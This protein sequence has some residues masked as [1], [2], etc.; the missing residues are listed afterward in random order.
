MLADRDGVPVTS[1]PHTTEQVQGVLSS[2]ERGLGPTGTATL[3]RM[4]ATTQ[5]G[6]GVEAV[7]GEA[8]GV[9]PEAIAGASAE[10][11]EGRATEPWYRRIVKKD[12]SQSSLSPDEDEGD[13]RQPTPLQAVD[14]LATVAPTE[15]GRAH[16]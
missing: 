12:R 10:A 16:V 1:L 9:A 6:Q 8:Q 13:A 4:H 11:G 2:G 3:Q 15:I 14:A 5:V 7:V